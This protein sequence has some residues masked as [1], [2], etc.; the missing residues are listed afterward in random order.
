MALKALL[1]SLDGLDA[2]VSALYKPIAE[3]DLA[4]KFVLDV[5]AVGDH[6]LENIG[7]LRN[8]LATTKQELATAKAASEGF[9]G[10]K[11]QPSTIAEKLR[12]LA[13]LEAIDPTAEA[14]KLASA[15]I[16]AATAKLS[17]A[18]NAEMTA[19]KAVAERYRG[20]IEAS[21]VDAQLNAAIAKHG[22]RHGLL[23]PALRSRIR[24]VEEGEEFKTQVLSKTGVPDIVIR[25]GKP[26]PMT[27][28]DLV[29]AMKADPEFGV[30][31]SASGASGSGAK[32]SNP[33][34][35]GTLKNPFA[36]ETWNLTEQS[37]LFKQDPALYEALKAQAA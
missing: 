23:G 36:K 19:Q 33:G 2:S 7:G 1:E 9:A 26:E 6:A 16:E 30:A 25:N 21:L 27:I 5:E 15:K 31:F 14:D 17:E 34:A 32:P 11:L 20:I 37:K 13:T 18:H 12:K 29:V 8:A 10:L 28:D 4:G 22:G 24:I 3:G 35:G